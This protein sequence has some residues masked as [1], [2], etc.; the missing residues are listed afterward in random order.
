MFI[1]FVMLFVTMTTTRAVCKQE[2]IQPF[3]LSIGMDTRVDADTTTNTRL[4]LKLV[5]S[6]ARGMYIAENISTSFVLVV[7]CSGTDLTF[8]FLKIGLQIIFFHCFQS[9]Q[10]ITPKIKKHSKNDRKYGVSPIC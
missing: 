9:Y 10:Q 5:L 3:G 8:H 2:A 7:V 1:L 6:I 4:F